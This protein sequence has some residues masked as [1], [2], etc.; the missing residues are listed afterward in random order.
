MNDNASRTNAQNIRNQ[1]KLNLF[2][3]N[4][5]NKLFKDQSPFKEK[6]NTPQ[7]TKLSQI[8]DSP[9]KSTEIAVRKKPYLLKSFEQLYDIGHHQLG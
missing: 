5:V 9:I 2:G 8:N 1:L 4:R 6:N 3:Q 7:P